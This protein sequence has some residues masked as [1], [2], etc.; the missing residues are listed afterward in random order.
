MLKE[1]KIRSKPHRKFIAS[2]PCCV[3]G[4]EGS[5]QAAHIRYENGG[6]MGLKPCDSYCLPLCVDCHAEQ[7]YHGETKFWGKARV[8]ARVLAKHLHA[9][10]GDEAEAIVLIRKFQ[11]QI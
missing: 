1:L 4:L 5:T 3:C 7:T 9:V 6:G 10:S 11:R 2:L 8:T